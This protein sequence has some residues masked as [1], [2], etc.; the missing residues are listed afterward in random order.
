MSSGY[1]PAALK[2]QVFERAKGLCEYCRSQA[3]YAVD[4]FVMDHI[5]PV[6]RGGESVAENLALSCQTCN[7]YKYTKT[8]AVDPV[9]LNV[10]SLFNPREMAWNEHFIWNENAEKMLGITPIGRATVA[11]LQTNRDGVRNMRRVL[12]LMNE[13]PPE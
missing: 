2:Q 7:N 10:V 9:T 6:S 8:E 13:H 1:V 3:R 5:Q 12:T 4:P 11:L